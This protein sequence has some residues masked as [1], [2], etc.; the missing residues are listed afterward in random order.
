VHLENVQEFQR[1]LHEDYQKLAIS[2][3]ITGEDPV[4]GCTVTMEHRTHALSEHA[5]KQFALYWLA[6]KPGGGFVTRQMLQAVRRRAEAPESDK[7]T[8]LPFQSPREPVLVAP[9][10]QQLTPQPEPVAA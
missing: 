4:K 3:R 10:R 8:P 7:K 5:R 6:I 1:F 9:A 2:F